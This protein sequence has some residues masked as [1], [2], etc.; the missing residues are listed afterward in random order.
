MCVDDGSMVNISFDYN[1]LSPW[2]LRYTDGTNNF[3]QDTL[4]DTNFNFNTLAEG[5]YSIIEVMDSNGCVATISGLAQVIIYSM[6]NAVI[7]PGDTTIYIGQNAYIEYRKF[8]T[9]HLVQ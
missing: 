8:C 4:N 7:S 1:G 9:L 2:D 6:P 3:N 5:D